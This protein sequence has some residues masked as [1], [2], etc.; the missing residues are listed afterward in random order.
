MA[1][2][3]IKMSDCEER[4]QFREKLDQI[5]L[6]VLGNGH[7]EKG[8]K[9]KVEQNTKNITEIHDFMK[10]VKSVFWKVIGT[11]VIGALSA[12]GLLIFQVIKFLIKGD[13]I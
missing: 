10:T 3:G 4:R 9:W 11:A 1:G 5:W 12:L 8:L 6:C 7:P 2:R 13:M